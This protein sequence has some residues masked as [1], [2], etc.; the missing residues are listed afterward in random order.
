[1]LSLMERTT[2]VNPKEVD[3]QPEAQQLRCALARSSYPALR[4]LV[5]DLDQR[6]LILRGSVPSFY[7]KQVAH[8]LA[9]SIAQQC[10][11]VDLIEVRIG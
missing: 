6:V 3:L 4:R 7:L 2:A 5:C 10:A 8:A 11:I 9:E 1:M